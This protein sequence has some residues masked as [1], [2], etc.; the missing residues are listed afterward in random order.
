MALIA[1]STGERQYDELRRLSD[2]GGRDTW[3]LPK[4][5]RL[6]DVLLFYIAAPLGAFVGYADVLTDAKYGLDRNWP[7]DYAAEI[8]GVR[9]LHSAVTR[10]EMMAK[11]PD[12]G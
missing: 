4:T 2:T 6:G 8:G 12:W 7:T 9:L 3:T 10:S 11:V 1:M 5:A